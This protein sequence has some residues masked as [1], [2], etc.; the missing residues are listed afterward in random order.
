[1]GRRHK[2]LNS[3]RWRALRRFILKRDDWTCQLCG[4]L[5][6]LAEIDHK[7]P[8]HHDSTID[9]YDA[10][11]LQ[12]LCRG[13]HLKKTEADM[14]RVPDLERERWQLRIDAVATSDTPMVD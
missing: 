3:A 4:K 8:M 11:N 9:P 7:I 6:G 12:C 1:M 13:C 2:A 10:T 5:L 14:G